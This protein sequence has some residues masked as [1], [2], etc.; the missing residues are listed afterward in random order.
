LKNNKFILILR[1]KLK[2]NILFQNIAV[3]ASGNIV[4]KLIVIL[5]TP[6]ITRLYTPEDYGVF[7]IFLSITGI[8]GSLS[9]LRYAVT[10][11][12]AREEKLAD[13][14]L[15]LCFIITFS[16]SL[17]WVVG[18]FLF[19]TYFT[20]I[21]SAELFK[22]FLWFIPITFLGQG[23]YE[24]LNNWAV[25]DKKFKLITRTKISQGVSSSVVKIGLGT[26]GIIPLG[27]F[28]GQIAQVFAGIGSLT[29]KL[30]KIKPS[31][32][33]S[34]S[35]EEI[36]F[37]A[38][39]YKKFPLLQS[40]SQLLLALG[41]QLPVLLIGAFY[42]AKVV[43]VFALAM[44]MINLPMDLIGQSVAQ[45]FYAEISKYGKN[46]PQKIYNLSVS[47]TKKLFWVS[48]IPIA[49]LIVLGPWLFATIFGPEWQ[50]AGLYSRYFSIIV[51]TRFISSPITNIFNVFEKQGLQLFL[52]ILRVV[53]VTLIFYISHLLTF[54]ANEAIIFYSI[55]MPFYS[56]IG[57][58]IVF[59]ILK[60]RKANLDKK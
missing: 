17:L 19:G 13:N 29:L 55:V 39:R 41:G 48:L 32:F 7:S 14:L 54:S 30:I 28:I 21:F 33:K 25:R 43:G 1:E 57:L 22:P 37:A 51:L 60:D 50:N 56:I 11:P 4:A 35:W 42:D 38:K 36:K 10:I 5:S 26:L 12:I 47:I 24:A 58:Y 59:K 34:F 49:V 3:V 2:S 27:L 52:N 31:F 6:I 9:T 53:I 16:L 20:E 40:W 15:K 44:G 23:I 46:K 8:I 18:I 45:V